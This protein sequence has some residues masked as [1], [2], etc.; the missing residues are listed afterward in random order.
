VE[1][2]KEGM[3][4]FKSPREMTEITNNFLS[5]KNIRKKGYYFKT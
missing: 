5:N 2:R 3:D 4:V 1:H